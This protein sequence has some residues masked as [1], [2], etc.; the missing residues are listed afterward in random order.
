MTGFRM[1]IP[2]AATFPALLRRYRPA[3]RATRLLLL[4]S[5][6]RRRC[7]AA[8]KKARDK[9]GQCVTVLITRGSLRVIGADG[10]LIK[11]GRQSGGLVA[12]GRLLA[13]RRAWTMLR[14][15]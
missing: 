12:P 1:V 3:Q 8:Q 11:R 13:M 10:A 5:C 4:A 2:L 9:R 7:L 14:L 15:S 6:D